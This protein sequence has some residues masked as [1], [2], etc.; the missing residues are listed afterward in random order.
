MGSGVA[1]QQRRL[2]H[3]RVLKLD[4]AMPRALRYQYPGAVYHL[5]A[6][7]NGGEAVFVADDDCKAFLHRLGQV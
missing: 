7:R 1:F 3:P 5:M 2:D 4:R 6:R